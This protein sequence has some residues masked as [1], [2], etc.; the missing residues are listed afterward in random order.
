MGARPGVPPSSRFSVPF[1]PAGSPQP[2]S[3]YLGSMLLRRD[4]YNSRGGVGGASGGSPYDPTTPSNQTGNVLLG[5]PPVGDTF[6]ERLLAGLGDIAQ[7]PQ[8]YTW[9]G[10]EAPPAAGSFLEGA[11]SAF[12]TVRGGMQN[13]AVAEA[14]LARQS[15]ADDLQQSLMESTIARN[16]SAADKDE[17]TVAGMQARAAQT[18]SDANVYR[19]LYPE[20]SG[21]SDDEAVRQGRAIKASKLIQQRTAAATTTPQQKLN[22]TMTTATGDAEG[23]TARFPGQVVAEQGGEAIDNSA[24]FIHDYLA[25]KY[26][27]MPD[28]NLW[29]IA[30]KVIAEHKKG[31]SAFSGY[32]QP[33]APV[34]QPSATTDTTSTG[35]DESNN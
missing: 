14:N 12:G 6:K 5:E 23:L 8:N 27:G 32:T 15:L 22:D 34:T 24:Q 7:E 10:P 4:L 26:P 19:G 1:R 25:K 29:G 33:P 18:T 13:R 2:E 31:K 21:L 30:S 17:A 16:H 3:N 11:L 9:R 35:P 28:G 20:L